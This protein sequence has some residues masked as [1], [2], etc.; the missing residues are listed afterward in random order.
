MRVACT[1][2]VV[3]GLARG[4]ARLLVET[5]R[6]TVNALLLPHMTAV[7][8]WRAASARMGTGRCLVLTF[9]AHFALA[10][11][12]ASTARML[13][14]RRAVIVAFIAVGLALDVLEFL[15][16]ANHA[17]GGTRSWRVRASATRRTARG[18][19]SLLIATD[20]ALGAS[21][22]ACK[23]TA[24]MEGTGRAI[25][26]AS[27]TRGTLH[28]ALVLAGAT[29]AAKGSTLVRL[30]LPSGAAL[31]TDLAELVLVCALFTRRAASITFCI[32]V[33]AAG[34]VLA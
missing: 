1:A 3:A 7:L 6:L 21:A 30:V 23:A 26:V 24:A 5:S 11:A 10:R 28:T 33:L 4:L 16:A 14:A 20:A 13:L 12:A 34:A 29:R 31:A 18:A 19:S 27:L 8:A 22:R 17:H 9:F 2:D 25:I 32:A 15:G